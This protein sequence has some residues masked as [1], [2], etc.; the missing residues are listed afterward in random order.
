VGQGNLFIISAPSGTGK[1]TILQRVL[2]LLPGVAFSVS[3]TTRAP[4]PAERAGV[5][6][7]F[8]GR[9]E[10]A[11]LRDRG[12]FLE[13]AEVHGNFYGTSKEAVGGQLARGIDLILDIDVQG[14]GQVRA[15]REW[16]AV[17]IFVVPPSWGELE[18]RLTAR[19][20][21]GAATIRLRL[22]NA[23]R[24]MAAAGQYDY[25]V[26]N[27]I[28]EEAVDTLRAVIIAERSRH[29]R[30]RAGLPLIFPVPAP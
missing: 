4:R 21:D 16:P 7:H 8:V 23:R 30:S 18:R 5:H 27:D 20:T 1:S 15:Q 12:G 28:L 24:E 17:S 6:Y 9:D 29:R 3:H 2:E 10:F 13:W 19:N 25:V 26:V 14:A 22:D 11:A